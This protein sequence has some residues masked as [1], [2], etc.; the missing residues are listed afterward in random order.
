VDVAFLTENL[1]EDKLPSI[2]NDFYVVLGMKNP[3]EP[4][5]MIEYNQETKTYVAAISVL[6]KWELSSEDHSE[7]TDPHLPTEISFY[8]QSQ[9]VR[10]IPYNIPAITYGK[11]AQVYA[12]LPN[13]EEASESFIISIQSGNEIV[14]THRITLDHTLVHH[15]R[16]LIH[17]LA[18]YKRIWY[19][20]FIY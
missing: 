18:A 14:A 6:P 20:N 5:I 17:R 9:N 15:S 3:S 12:F 13:L 19:L 11:T 10:Q 8:W 1:S 16:T 2:H 7:N 4:R